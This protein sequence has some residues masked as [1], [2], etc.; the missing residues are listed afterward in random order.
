MQIGAIL[1]A[2]AAHDRVLEGMIQEDGKTST[3]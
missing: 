2:A 3:F 1:P